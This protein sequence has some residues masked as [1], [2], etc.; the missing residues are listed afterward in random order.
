MKTSILLLLTGSI[1]CQNVLSQN[2]DMEELSKLNKDWLNS[3]PTRDTTLLSKILA[4]DF[5]LISPSGVKMSKVDVIHNVTTQEPLYI[6]IDSIDIRLL[7]PDVG[8]ISAY[9]SFKTKPTDKKIAAKN[10]YQDVYVK[11]KGRWFAVAAHVTLLN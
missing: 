4:D 9:L 10:C 2:K 3:Y 5:I 11:R 7:T 6:S 8:L 1:I